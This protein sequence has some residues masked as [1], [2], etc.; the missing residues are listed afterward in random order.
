[1]S[2]P[3]SSTE[4]IEYRSQT[5]RLAA[6]VEFT[7]GSELAGVIHLQASPLHSSGFETPLEMLDRPEA[8]YPVRLADDT[9]A[10]VSKAQTVAVGCPLEE[11]VDDP[12]RASIATVLPIE[13][14]MTSQKRYRGTAFCELPPGHTRPLD[15]FNESGPFVAIVN[16]SHTYYV[17]RSL[18][19][20]V[21]PAD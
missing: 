12:E 20:A 18:T 16:E 3:F 19:R 4:R 5:K 13:V 2:S 1:M 9:V 14:E 6:T 15:F 10:L 7:D 21:Y 17:N 11:P 8:F